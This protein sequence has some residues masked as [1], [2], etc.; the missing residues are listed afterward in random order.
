M[1][2]SA[3][4]ARRKGAE[5]IVAPLTTC[6]FGRVATEYFTASG[7]GRQHPGDPTPRLLELLVGERVADVLPAQVEVGFRL[8]QY[9]GEALGVVRRDHGVPTASRQK[10]GHA[11]EVGRLLWLEGDHRPE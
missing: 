4:N 8:Q 6:P 9:G 7:E 2:V 11:G 10:D 3:P 5:K 1:L